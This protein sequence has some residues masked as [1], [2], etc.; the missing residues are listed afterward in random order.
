MRWDDWVDRENA[1]RSL[2]EGDEQLDWSS[3]QT[4]M[5]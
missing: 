1:W 4:C 5:E 3:S 2:V